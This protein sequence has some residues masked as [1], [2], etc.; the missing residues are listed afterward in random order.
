MRAIAAACMVLAGSLSAMAAEDG[1]L[2]FDPVNAERF[3]TTFGLPSGDAVIAKSISNRSAYPNLDWGVPL[4]EAEAAELD[5]R[6]KLQSKSD[7][8]ID[9]AVAQPEY[10]G[11]YFDHQNDGKAV[12]RF[13]G[14]L[15][16]HEA[17][18]NDLLPNEQK[19]VVKSA[20]ATLR[21]LEA[22]ADR[23]V[24]DAGT[25]E[26]SGI[27]IVEVYADVT[28]N[29][30]V[31]GLS[32]ARSGAQAS[33]RASHSDLIRTKATG[34]IA[35]DACTNRWHCRP[36]WK[37]GL[38]IKAIGYA[39]GKCSSAFLARRNSSGNL[40]LVTAGHCLAL[41]GGAGV[42]WKHDGVNIGKAKSG[43]T[44]ANYANSDVGWID[45]ENPGSVSPRNRF[46]ASS[47]SDIRSINSVRASADQQVGNPICR[48]AYKT[49]YL[50]G[51]IKVRNDSVR[52]VDG[53]W[54]KNL[55]KVSFDASPGDSG[56]IYFFGPTVY[57]I[58]ADSKTGIDPPAD[59]RSWYTPAQRAES[60]ADLTICTTSGC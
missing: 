59:G 37:G 23:V 55:F 18:L 16:K 44:W 10:A 52:D 50:C 15:N 24:E 46:Y 13:A 49:Y 28:T 53:R 21:E 36:P 33:L 25:L 54:I 45:V 29:K 27:D 11:M 3:R 41:N 58:H 4:S 30:V 60:K 35:P 1:D 12:F 32:G 20:T 43:W 48:S 19:L 56:G 47:S 6:T 51:T 31:V 2:T 39:N 57:G 9:Y 40:V 17:R 26:A 7:R 5:T 34:S 38:Y 14:N 22:V 42:T 8:A